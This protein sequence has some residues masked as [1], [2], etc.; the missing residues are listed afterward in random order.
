MGASDFWT[1]PLSNNSSKQIAK[2]IIQD[3]KIKSVLDFGAGDRSFKMGLPSY[4]TYHSFDIDISTEQDF[5]DINKI[6][7][8][9]DMIVMFASIEHLSLDK[10]I[11]YLQKF[12]KI[13]KKEGYLIISTN[14]VFH[15]IG[16]RADLTHLQP[17]S[18]RDLNSLLMLSGF[19]SGKCYRIT[20]LNKILREFYT[21]LSKYI[22]RPYRIDFAPE[23][24]LVSKFKGA[25]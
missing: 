2:K 4:V 12:K 16:I 8:K 18:P 13:L 14:N 5:H 10:F 17:Y 25:I 6:K 15:N 20:M 11:E 21:I 9:Y 1:L 19:H 7:D 24:C 23:I 3:N 22:L